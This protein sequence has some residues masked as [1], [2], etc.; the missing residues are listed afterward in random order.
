MT[1]ELSK[2]GL[3]FSDKLLCT[4]R[5]GE[6]LLSNG[7]LK[8]EPML[9]SYKAI[10]D[11]SNMAR[12]SKIPCYAYATSA[13]RDAKNRNEFLE[14][15]SPL[16]I[17]VEVL[18]G[19]DEGR[20]AFLAANEGTGTLI[21]IGGASSQIVTELASKS[22]PIGCVRAKDFCPIDDF[23]SAR[24]SLFRWFDEVYKLSY[25]LE[26]PFTGVGGTITT[27]G[28]LIQGQT[29][30][31]GDRFLNFSFT[32]AELDSVLI[33]LHSMGS[34]RKDHPLLKRRHDVILYGGLILA[35]LLERYKIPSLRPSTSD[36][37]EGYAY[38]LFNSAR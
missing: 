31:D 36:G 6:G 28:A 37:M 3:L 26:P 8:R 18:S 13:V 33:D 23:N 24:L 34:R 30:F 16:N 29:E 27:L 21:D 19:E 35:Y 32:A 7:L 15:L 20:Y 11:F 14:L 12:L 10:A 2:G 4:T 17:S 22:F 9:N 5:L 1:A 25:S 38:K